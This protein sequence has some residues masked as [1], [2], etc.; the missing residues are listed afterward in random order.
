MKNQY[1]KKKIDS[2]EK[3]IR[4][5]ARINY[6]NKITNNKSSK[7]RNVSSCCNEISKRITI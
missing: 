5:V 2:L 4:Y 1:N 7:I 6:K 3:R